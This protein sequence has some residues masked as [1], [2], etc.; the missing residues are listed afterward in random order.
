MRFFQRPARMIGKMAPSSRTL[1]RLRLHALGLGLFLLGLIAAISLFFPAGALKDR[2]AR[3]LSAR[4]GIETHI[5][6]LDPVFPLGLHLKE[7]QVR[8]PDRR[9]DPLTLAELRLTP[10]WRTLFG[11]HPA[12]E[13]Q[14]RLLGGEAEAVVATDGS[15]TAEFGGLRLAEA[16]RTPFPYPLSGILKG[17]ILV[18]GPPLAENTPV[19]FTLTLADARVAGLEALGVGKGEFAAGTVTAAGKGRGRQIRL[20]ELSVQGGDL[21]LSGQGSLL[22]GNTAASSRIS[23]QIRLRPTAGLDPGLRDLLALSGSK[24][25][26]EGYYNFRISGTLARPVLR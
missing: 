10:R 18:A 15:L 13:L 2:L 16:P 9:F 24:P 4:S 20:T 25:D 22:L 12:A 1:G 14:G 8:F 6:Q 3:E 21:E 23:L 19:D 11:D 17:K 7:V 26:S 5:G